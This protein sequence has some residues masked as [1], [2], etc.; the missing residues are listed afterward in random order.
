MGNLQFHITTTSKFFIYINQPFIIMLHIMLSNR[1]LNYCISSSCPLEILHKLGFG[2]LAFC[3]HSHF[4]I[5]YAFTYVFL[6]VTHWVRLIL[7]G[8]QFQEEPLI[9][10]SK[11]FMGPILILVTLL[12]FI[13][14]GPNFGCSFFNVKVN[15]SFSF[16]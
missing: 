15:F 12:S 16:F 2:C 1:M 13:K 4:I 11:N 8:S 3:L 9:L 5:L 10:I 7:C 14:L 6:N